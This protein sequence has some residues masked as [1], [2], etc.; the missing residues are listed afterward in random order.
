MYYKYEY[1]YNYNERNMEKSNIVYGKNA[2][3]ELLKAKKRNINKIFIAKNLHYDKKLNEIFDL[4]R[5]NNILYNITPKENIDKQFKE[6]VKHQGIIAFVSPIEYINFYDFIENNL[7]KI[8]LNSLKLLLLDGIEDPHNLGSIIRTCVCAGYNGIII[9]KHKSS[10]INYIVEK[11][12]AGAINYIPIILVNNL[13]NI[14]KELKKQNIWIIATS[15]NSKDNYFDIN[16]KNMNFAIIMGSE[17]NGIKQSILNSADF[18]VKIP[19]I[20]NF[21]SLNVSNAASILIY[22]TIRQQFK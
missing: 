19:M 15:V 21:N 16:Y 5:E 13:G 18:K 3:I 9:P 11:A 17:G 20:N 14:I 4:A 6:T 8:R 10:K 7:E 22:E 1:L 2:V 12:S